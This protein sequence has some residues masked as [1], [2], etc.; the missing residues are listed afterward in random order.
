MG[1]NENEFLARLLETFRGE[2]QEHLEAIASGLLVLEQSSSPGEEYDRVVEQVFRETHSLKGAA[3]AVGLKEIETLCQQQESVFSAVKKGTLTLSPDSFDLFHAVVHALE[4]LL[5]KESGV[6]TSDLIKQLKIVLTGG[7]IEKS[8]SSP[9][10]S[11]ASL[12]VTSLTQDFHPLSNVPDEQRP[13]LQPTHKANSQSQS[14]TPTDRPTQIEDE[15][16]VRIDPVAHEYEKN[17]YQGIVKTASTV[18]ISSERLENLFARS[19]DL[20]DARLA[21]SQRSSSI[22][23]LLQNF[24]TWR[25]TWTQITTDLEY[26]RNM[27]EQTGSLRSY[28]AEVERVAGFLDYNHNF[29]QKLEKELVSISRAAA[30]DHYLLDTA[31]TELIDE[32]KQV[33]LVPAVSILERYPRVVR[34]LSRE[35]GKNVDVTLSGTEIEIDRRI[36]EELKDPIL[37]IIRNCIDHG[38]E[39]PEIRRSKGKPERGEIR[40]EVSHIRGHQAEIRISDDGGGLDL[41][42]IRSTAISKGIITTEEAEGLLSDQVSHLIFRSG[43]STSKTISTISGRGLGLAIVLEKVELIGGSVTVQSNQNGTTFVLTLPLSLATFKGIKVMTGNHLYFLPLR[44][45]ERVM[46]INHEELKTI[47]ARTVIE[48]ENEP[49]SVISLAQI[50]G[51][52]DSTLPHQKTHHLM[53]ASASGIK[54]CLLVDEIWGAQEIVVRNLGSQLRRVR[55]ISGASVTGDGLVIPV[56]NCEDLAATISGTSHL[57]QLVIIPDEKISK[58]RILVVEDSITSRMLL[59]NILKGAGYQVETAVDGVDA[60]IKLKQNKVDVVVSDI[61]MPRMNG[62]VL[63][64]KIRADPLYT[65]LPVILVT[66]LDSREDREHGIMVGANAYIVK[67][68]FDQSNLLEVISRHIL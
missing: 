32:I 10:T 13:P 54:F 34:D 56:I 45:I 17:Q 51:L 5:A 26:L 3:R 29:I 20:M 46:R 16:N 59:K 14:F 27:P 2:A 15:H 68:S 18:K 33:I 63:T 43:L 23:N 42:V 50:L 1:L 55:H 4:Q 38:I 30:R 65:D 49:L 57:S 61:D 48:I 60:L 41:E 35:R 12:E 39:S 21:I 36:L 28:G 58:Q 11:S 9:I 22:R 64:E 52:P 53:V 40:I 62:F 47:E 19:D 44:S 7:T 66:S 31:T 25:W 6:K 67:S 24:L 8:H 37:H